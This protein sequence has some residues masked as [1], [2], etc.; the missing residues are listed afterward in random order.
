MGRKGPGATERAPL[1]AWNGS[2]TSSRSNGVSED[3]RAWLDSGGRSVIF[4][5]GAVD[6]FYRG[7]SVARR[8]Q[9][10]RRLHP[11]IPFE[12]PV[13]FTDQKTFESAEA[14]ARNI[15]THGIGLFTAVRVQKGDLLL[16]EVSLADAQNTRLHEAVLGEVVWVRPEGDRGYSAGVFCARMQKDHPRLYSH[17]R[18]LEETIALPDEYWEERAE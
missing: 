10:N 17:L 3:L 7:A 13:R 2:R 14:E 15:S 8:K 16:I 4:D 5:R 1:P 9:P 18:Y 12:M 6:F 11:R